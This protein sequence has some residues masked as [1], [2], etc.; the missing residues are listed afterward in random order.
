M[1]HIP[2]K[3]HT[4]LVSEIRKF[5]N[6]LE[7]A[8]IKDL[9][10]SDTVM[11]ITDMLSEIFGYDKYSDITSE[12]AIRGTF[13][14][15]AVKIDGQLKLL[16]EAKAIGLDLKE[17]HTKQAINYAAN[18]G[19][20]W[21]ALTNGDNWKVYRVSFGKPISQE[22][23]IDFKISEAN[24]KNEECLK[25]LFA[26]SKEGWDKSAIDQHYS[27]SQV[28]NKFS[29]SALLLSESILK[30]L[31]RDLRKVFPDVKVSIEDITELL[32]KEVLR[33]EVVEGEKAINV[34]RQ[35][36]RALQKAKSN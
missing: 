36:E 12:H 30:A 10:E 9:N 4:R 22:L 8:K 25:S 20:E 6:I 7:S 18:Q 27:R 21:V 13:C 34:K 26:I 5:Q 23:I 15:L 35:V 32:I 16:I 29:M 1:A 31:K 33:R 19:V 14:D 11:I 24:A 3:V 17:A 2:K 28:L